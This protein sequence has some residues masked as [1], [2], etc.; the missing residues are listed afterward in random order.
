MRRR[1]RRRSSRRALS[2][3]EK[4]EFERFLIRLTLQIEQDKEKSAHS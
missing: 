4:D 2:Q 3:S 1:A